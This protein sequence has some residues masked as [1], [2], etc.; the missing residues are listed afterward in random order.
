MYTQEVA[1]GRPRRTLSFDADEL[2][3]GRPP[4]E[5][6]DKLF[7]VGGVKDTTP[8]PSDLLPVCSLI[9]TGDEAHHAGVVVLTGVR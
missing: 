7:G 8:P 5:I 3:V 4:P 6:S 1:A 9:G 2:Q